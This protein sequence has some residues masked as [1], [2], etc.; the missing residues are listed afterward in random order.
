MPAEKGVEVRGVRKSFHGAEVVRGVDLD[1]RRGEFFALLGPS[2]CGK[3]TLLRTIAGFETPDEGTVLLGGRDVTGDPPE[4][5][6]VN[7]VFQHYALFPHLDVFENVAFGLRVRRTPEAEV[8][9]RVSEALS[10][11]Q[12]AGFERRATARLSGGQQQRVALARALVN[13]PELLLLDE[14]MAALDEKLREDMREELKA[15]QLRIGVSFLYVTHDQEEAL[16]LAD[17]IAVMDGGR[18]VQV[19]TPQ[20]IYESPRTAF[21]ADFVGTTNLLKGRVVESEDLL[22][23]AA[24]RRVSIALEGVGRIEACLEGSAVP[25]EAAVVSLR[26]ERVHVSSAPVEGLSNRV[27]GVI[28][29]TV[30]LGSDIHY[31]VRLD[32]GGTLKAHTV[33][34]PLS[35]AR[36]VGEPVWLGWRAEDACVLR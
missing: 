18:V 24:R 31:T 10:T 34:S 8:R 12:L 13:R 26:P 4:R 33:F 7:M 20:E 6:P 25:G 1:I 32:A 16:E 36:R 23:E 22:L 35:P 15:L 5:R 11:V 27:Q 17:R 21:V 9:A 14:P 3:T 19:G 30:F 28:E 29:R 2:G